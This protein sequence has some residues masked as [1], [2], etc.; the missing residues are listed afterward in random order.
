MQFSGNGGAFSGQNDIQLEPQM[1]QQDSS[2]GLVL[3]PLMYWVDPVVL[4]TDM[5]NRDSYRLEVWYAHNGWFDAKVTGWEIERVRPQGKRRGGVVDIRGIIEPG[6][7]SDVSELSLSGLDKPRHQTLKAAVRNLALV[8]EGD[9]F[10]LGYT[11]A[12]RQLIL[13]LLYGTG[14]PYAK[15]DVDIQADPLAYD[16]K[17]DFQA[18]TGIHARFGEA[19]IQGND[20]VRVDQIADRLT[21][22]PGKEFN[23]DRLRESQANLFEMGTFSVVRVEPDVSDPTQK[24]VPIDVLVSE[25]KWRTLRFGLGSSVQKTVQEGLLTD[26][27][28]WSPRISSQFR[29]ANLFRQLIQWDVRASVGVYYEPATLA[30]DAVLADRQGAHCLS[31]LAPGLSKALN[32]DAEECPH[33]LE[34]TWL[35]GTTAR[36]PRILGE[37][38]GLEANAEIER[39]VFLGAFPE[40]AIATS[41]AAVYQPNRTL[42]FRVGPAVEQSRFL[43]ESASEERSLQKVYGEGFENPYVVVALDQRLIIDRRDVKRRTKIVRGVSYATVGLRETLPTHVT[44]QRFVGADTDTRLIHPIPIGHSG[45]RLESAVAFRGEILVP[46]SDR[47]VGYPERIFLGGANDMRGWR[48]GQLGPFDAIWNPDRTVTFL[49]RGG[50]VALQTSYEMRYPWISGITLA[51]FTDIGALAETPKE[52]GLDKLRGSVGVGMRYDTLVGPIRFDVSVRKVLPEDSRPQRVLPATAGFPKDSRSYDL[53][54]GL[55]KEK[56][57]PPYAIVL[58]L[59]IGEAI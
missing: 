14:F 20:K 51:T 34:P 24:D 17:I 27:L 5:L 16:V 18:D 6:I 59:A 48:T 28:A 38:W 33:T 50:T 32:G 52:L 37:R 54:S 44:A 30:D 11:D 4:D 12:D 25:S 46:Y 15:V 21:F 35:L 58:F 23:I 55:F 1:E 8:R 31:K 43:F 39:D 45:Y 41:L 9:P 53:I 47:P 57:H 29:H 40:R 36:W 49:S 22:E 19:R 13:D 2:F 7:Q 42:Q 56:T 3:W 10:N 26:G